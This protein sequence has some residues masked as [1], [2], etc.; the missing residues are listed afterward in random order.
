MRTLKDYRAWVQAKKTV[1]ESAGFNVRDSD[2]NPMLF[3]WQR[4]VVR[5]AL[6]QG[7]AALFEEC[8]LGKTF[9]QV[10][11]ARLVSEHT[12]GRVL[13]LAPLAVA[14]QTIDEARKIGV[15]AKYCRSQDAVDNAE[16]RIIVTNYDMMKSLDAS[17]FSGVVLDESS[18][19]KSFSGSIRNQ[20]IASFD[21][22]PY[23]LACTAT[24]APNDNMELGNH[25]EFL[26]VMKRTE[27]LAM[28]FKH[29]G[30][31]TAVWRIKKHAEH[32]FW[33]WVTSWAVCA[34]KPSD[35][36]YSDEGFD[37]PALHLHEHTVKTDHTHAFA[38]GQLFVDGTVSA[39]AMWKE[40][41]FTNDARCEKAAEL[42]DASGDEP[43]IVWCDTNDEADILGKRI[44]DAVEVRGSD[45]VAKKEAGLTAF[46]DGTATRIITKPDI[47]GFGLNWQHCANM[48]FV[49]VTY[50]FERTYQALR[51]SWRFGQKR[52]VHAHLIYAESEGNIR[53][54]LQIKQKQHHEMQQHMND[55]M[56]EGG[57]TMVK[58]ARKTYKQQTGV[59]APTW[60]Q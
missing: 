34:S 52:D 4:H 3:D 39:T 60:L 41:G 55:A 26:G 45:S 36:G 58:T 23:R 47:A 48:A 29:D 9:Q 5:W 18:I 2:I 17:A 42:V 30:G 43:F 22:T 57:I 46:T 16:E 51:R 59:S 54:A 49:G 25:A 11:W 44:S 56:R 13:I 12:G 21:R 38:Q 15:A 24:P 27:M 20:L 32:D 7:R 8:G 1:A 53:K 10:E 14:H 50:S 28:Y 40:R 19:L 37:L 33:R 35:L 31:D 6:K